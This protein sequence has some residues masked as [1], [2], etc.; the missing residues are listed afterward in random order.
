MTIESFGWRHPGRAE[1]AVRNVSLAIAP[2]ERVLVAGSSGAGKSTL[3]RAI[4]GVVEPQDAAQATGTISYHSS[5]AAGP[6]GRALSDNDARSQVGL[7]MQD[8]ETNLLLTRVGDD[9]AFGLENACVPRDQIWPRVTQALS[10]VGF[11]YPLDRPTSALSGGEKQR[12]GLAAMLARRPGLLILDEPTANLDPA[13]AASTLAALTRV[14][15]QAPTTMIVVEH[16]IE[17]II[18]L[19]DRMVVLTPGGL[20]ADGA[21]AEVIAERAEE[22]RQCGIFVPGR[23]VS[24]G[25]A[26]AAKP[27]VDRTMHCDRATVIRQRSQAPALRSVSLEITNAS[28]TAIVGENGAGKSTLARVL[29]GLLR[30]TSGAAWVAG[31]DQPVHKLKA[32]KLAQLVGTVFQEPDHQFVSESV[33]AELLV[34]A[35]AMGLAK[36]AANDRVNE[37]L[38]LL[39]LE[40]LQSVNPFTLSG[41]EK[42]RLAVG[43]A[44]VAAP[45]VLI[46]DEPTF[47]QD[48]NSWRAIVELLLARLAAGTSIVVITHDEELVTAL[49]ARRITLA[50]GQV[51]E[52]QFTSAAGGVA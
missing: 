52:Q 6:L 18:D 2:G 32:R 50:N 29:G 13:G 45:R 10:D 16:R 23:V 42:R 17:Q 5:D 1:W 40:H 22:L 9:V 28:A 44:L 49:G 30:P 48:A 12:V 31:T 33:R 7:M 35:H 14:L 8:P 34:G 27:G 3:L 20:I 37:M 19:V 51:L 26:R 4:A 39:G 41:G 43:V 25:L 46:L 11:R 47:G 21:P 36:A 38:G 24:R 15:D